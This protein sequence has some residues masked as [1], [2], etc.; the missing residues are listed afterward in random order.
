MG[1]QDPPQPPGV[2]HEGPLL[3]LLGEVGHEKHDEFVLGRRD[4]LQPEQELAANELA[5]GRAHRLELPHGKARHVAELGGRDVDPAEGKGGARGW[6][7]EVAENGL[8]DVHD[9][10]YCE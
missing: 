3:L 1:L 6:L 8:E 4:L 2:D 9:I 5:L 10:T 7:A